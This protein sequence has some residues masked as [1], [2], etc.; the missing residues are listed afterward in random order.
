VG[1]AGFV[2][3]TLG[4]GVPSLGVPE[5]GDAPVS[6]VIVADGGAGFV[7]GA[8][9]PGFAPTPAGGVGSA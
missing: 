1:A 4:D 5:G 9:V 6:G 2:A 7:V 3:G 8:G